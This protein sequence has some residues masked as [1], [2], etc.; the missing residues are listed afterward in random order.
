[1]L[2]VSM[3][4]FILKQIA[5]DGA[6]QLLSLV[7]KLAVVGRPDGGC[8]A[9]LDLLD[10]SSHPSLLARCS[11]S[12]NISLN[13]VSDTHHDSKMMTPDGGF[14]A[15]FSSRLDRYCTMTPREEGHVG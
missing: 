11:I 4:H 3:R 7:L 2:P 8:P 14:F 9:L 15:F 5:V 10:C 6:G 13:T 1:M 12:R